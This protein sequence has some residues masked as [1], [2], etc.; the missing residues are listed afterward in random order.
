V[1][2]AERMGAD[3]AARMLGDEGWCPNAAEAQ[4]E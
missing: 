2:F 3:A 4:V 1:W